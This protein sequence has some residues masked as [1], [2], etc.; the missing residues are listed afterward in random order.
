[1]ID[2]DSGN[3]ANASKDVLL[4]LE[5]T[6]AFQASA[7]MELKQE[8]RQLVTAIKDNTQNSQDNNDNRL[9]GHGIGAKE[10]L[11]TLRRAKIA[12]E[13][14]MKYDKEETYHTLV[15]PNQRTR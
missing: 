15:D 8:I 9:E 2:D 3:A 14:F 13:E 4:R 7:L 11:S 5:N 10:I 12:Q 6:L 1:M